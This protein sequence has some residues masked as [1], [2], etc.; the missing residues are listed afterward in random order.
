MA[1]ALPIVF[2]VD[3]DVSVRQSLEL[4]IRTQGWDVESFE[5]AEQFLCRPRA[6]VPS[7]LVFDMT[8]PDLSGLDLQ[9]RISADRCDLPIIF[10]TGN[11]DVPTTVQAMK[12]GAVELL[13]KPFDDETLLG[14]IRYALERSRVALASETEQSILRERYTSLTEREKEIMDLVVQGLINKQTAVRLGIS[15]ITVKAHRGKVMR[16]MAAKSLA[17]LVRMAG[18][19]GTKGRIIKGN[20]AKT[21]PEACR[22]ATS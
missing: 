22:R 10:I 8:L 13:M 17:D 4:L 11:G 12:G 9:R 7:C 20:H 18:N 6:F 5:C 1:H 2:V 19:L 14:A 3:H 16:K 21:W 15:E